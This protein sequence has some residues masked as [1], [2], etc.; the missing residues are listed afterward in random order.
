MS[1]APL[2]VDQSLRR[3]SAADPDDIVFLLPGNHFRA[4]DQHVLAVETAQRQDALNAASEGADWVV[5]LG[6]DEIIPNMGVVIQHLGAAAARRARALEFRARMFYARTNDRRFLERCARWWT[7]QAGFPG[8]ILVAAGTTLT[9][10]REAAQAPLYRVD[11][12]PWSND[13]AHSRAARVHAV[14]PC[15]QAI[16]QLSWVR[17][18][19]QMQEKSVV[20]G[21]ASS[22]DRGSELR[23]WRR[24]ANPLRRA[25]MAPFAPSPFARFR[26]T[27]LPQ[28]A[29]LE[30]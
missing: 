15:E 7:T 24:A 3:V 20:S 23:R 8:P 6:T 14:I 11:I 16:L 1:G 2:S 18:E 4:N 22:R 17:T 12:S 26:L 27:R 29:G 5:Q 10:A 19:E 28:F 21:Y 30:P 25:A 9:H 13:P